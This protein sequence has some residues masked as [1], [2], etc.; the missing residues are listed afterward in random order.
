MERPIDIIVLFIIHNF[1]LLFRQ[2][3][4][5]LRDTSKRYF[6]Q[7][8]CLS[9]PGQSGTQRDPNC[10]SVSELHVFALV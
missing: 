3:S 5:E 10:V 2:T 4:Q 1:S 8:C 7:S 6:G 9:K